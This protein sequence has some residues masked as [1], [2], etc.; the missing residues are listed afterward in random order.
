MFIDL[1]MHELR[2]SKDSFLL[3]EDIVKIAKEKGLDA[4]CITDHD[5][6]DIRSYAKEYSLK[7]GYPIFTGIE[8]YSLQGD[9][10]AY[11][12]NHYPEDRVSAQEFIDLVNKQGGV[13]Y[14]A[15]P[16]R[17]N[18]RGLE[19]HLDELHGLHGIEVLNGSTH[20]DACRKAA[21]YSRK[22]NLIPVGASD[23]HVKEK[24]GVCATY[25][26]MDIHSEEELVGAFLTGG[27]KPAYYKDGAYHVLDL[28]DF[29][30]E[31]EWMKK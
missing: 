16:F 18:R 7:T 22:L 24:V 26:P 1:H 17:N 23:C 2:N 29:P 19:E 6:M 28:D 15:H 10:I 8:Y 3:L 14:S 13:C 21:E 31:E 25:F 27:M 20:M 12:I 4:I 30:E 5:S 11:G 9:I